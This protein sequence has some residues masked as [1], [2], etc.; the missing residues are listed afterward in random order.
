MLDEWRTKI[1]KSEIV[2]DESSAPDGV[3]GARARKKKIKEK[4][5]KVFSKNMSMGRVRDQQKRFEEEL[6]REKQN[7]QDEELFK[8]V[9]HPDEKQRNELSKRLNLESRQVKFWFQ[10]RLTQMKTQLERHENSIL[11]QE[12]DKLWLRTC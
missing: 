7:Q 5:R 10:N 4:Q 6:Q 1:L 9:P 2:A 11:R 12:N 8:E 3:D